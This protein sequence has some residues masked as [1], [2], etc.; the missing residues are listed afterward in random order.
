MR[1]NI[2]VMVSLCKNS[3]VGTE[4]EKQERIARRVQR[5]FMDKSMVNEFEE[6]YC[7]KREPK[8]TESYP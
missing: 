6:H 5:M 4:E 8:Y 2:G 3:M 1:S 7:L